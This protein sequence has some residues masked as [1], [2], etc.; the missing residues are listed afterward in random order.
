MS[1]P[2]PANLP[3]S[4]EPRA[5]VEAV[6]A[7]SAPTPGAVNVVNLATGEEA[8]YHGLPPHRAVLCAHAQ[9]E[10]RDFNTWAYSGLH[11]D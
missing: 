1:V 4:P 5:A 3:T 11:K 2:S 7:G 8:V 9:L 6:P 10:H